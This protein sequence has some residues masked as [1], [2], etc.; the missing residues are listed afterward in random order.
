MAMSAE[1]NKT[2]WDCI[3]SQFIVS[4]KVDLFLKEIEEVCKKHNLSI[5]HEDSHG[6]FVIESY[7]QENIKWLNDSCINFT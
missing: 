6:N 4:P 3:S 7:D 1:I 2:H 5:S